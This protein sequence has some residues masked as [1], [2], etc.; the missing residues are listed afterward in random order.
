MS[1]DFFFVALFVLLALLAVLALLTWFFAGRIEAH[2]PAPG[3]YLEVE[4]ERI[5]YRSLGDGPP[6]V[7]V[8]GLAGESRNFDYLPLKDLA[9][10]WRLVLIDRPGAGHTRRLVPGRAGIAAQAHLV[11]SFIRAMKF[12]RPPLLVGH[13]LGGAIA[14]GVALED[15]GCIAGLAL[16]APL[17]HFTPLVPRPFR[18]MAIR[19]PWLRHLFAHVL[20]VP[21]A[22]VSTPAVLA[23]LFG[24]DRPPR[25]FALRG[26][27]LMSLRPSA[28]I[29]ASTDMAAIEA[30]LL[31]QQERYDSIRVPVRV[32][33]GRGD[34]V[35][36]WREQ[37]EELCRKLPSVNL[38]VIAGGHM[39]PVSAAAETA[40]WLEECARA[41]HG[42]LCQSAGTA[43]PQQ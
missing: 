27:G 10:R 16:I 31:P 9:Q 43:S 2:F 41:V 12:E 35:L 5:H 4:G 22:I 39:I 6:V 26:G 29:G 21:V 15:P 25:D 13:S 18:A 40:A 14:L 20:S 37:G 30:D 11:A 19:T 34:R 3:R 7:L 42:D 17:T 8:H 33:Y 23:A 38:R 1:L 36:D 32:L 24:P 28:F